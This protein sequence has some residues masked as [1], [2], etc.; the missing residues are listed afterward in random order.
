MIKCTVCDTE[1]EKGF[2]HSN[3]ISCSEDCSQILQGRL[4]AIHDELRAE[5]M[6]EMPDKLD[7][8]DFERFTL[9]FSIHFLN[10]LKPKDRKKLQRNNPLMLIPE[11]FA[12]EVKDQILRHIHPAYVSETQ[13]RGHERLF[14]GGTYCFRQPVPC[15]HVVEAMKKARLIT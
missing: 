4:K 1:S 7:T 10:Q 13:A 3:G 11:Q 15:D 14:H 12:L 5:P 6:E 2:I 8:A 9:K